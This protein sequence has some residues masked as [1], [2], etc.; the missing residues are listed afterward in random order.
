MLLIICHFVISRLSKHK[1]GTN[2][3]KYFNNSVNKQWQCNAPGTLLGV[4]RT[5]LF[6]SISAMPC[7]SLSISK[8]TRMMMI[9]RLCCCWPTFG[10][11]DRSTIRKAIVHS[12]LYFNL[13]THF[14]ISITSRTIIA[15]A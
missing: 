4:I 12:R 5:Q 11:E 1:Y 6:W 7:C 13:F 14:L 2:I 10:T 3:L 15:A 8:S 9:L